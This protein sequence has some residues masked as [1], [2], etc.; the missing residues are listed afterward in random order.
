MTVINRSFFALSVFI[1][2]G[3]A[4]KKNTVMEIKANFLQGKAVVCHFHQSKFHEFTYVGTEKN[5][6][7]GEIT[8]CGRVL[9]NF[10]GSN[11]V[12]H[13]VFFGQGSEKLR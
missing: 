10:H 5:L 13:G 2:G 11:G 12:L 4:I 6:T 7:V 8:L 9:K 3:N 1:F